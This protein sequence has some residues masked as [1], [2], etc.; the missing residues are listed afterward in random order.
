MTVREDAIVYQAFTGNGNTTFS[1]SLILP[2]PA[3][4]GGQLITNDFFRVEVDGAER[5]DWD[6]VNPRVGF[7]VEIEITPAPAV[8]A[9][10]EV[11][12][13]VPYAQDLQLD[14]QGVFL[15]KSIERQ[16]DLMVL[17][18]KQVRSLATGE[19][20]A[21]FT[22]LVN[23]TDFREAVAS[24]GARITAIAAA[25]DMLE[26]P[27]D[28]VSAAALATALAAYLPRADIAAQLATDTL[29][30]TSGGGT[31]D[32]TRN[33]DG[34]LVVG[35]AVLG[36]L[37]FADA[38]QNG[39]A[40]LTAAQTAALAFLAG[41]GIQAK[42]TALTADR[43]RGSLFTFD[44]AGLAIVDHGNVG[45]VL[46]SRGAAGEPAFTSPAAPADGSVTLEK[47]AAGAAGGL[48]FIGADGSPTLLPIGDPGQQIAVSDANLPTWTSAASVSGGARAILNAEVVRMA[49]AAPMSPASL[50]ANEAVGSGLSV[51]IETTA[52]NSAIQLN[53][54][55][56]VA[57]AVNVEVRD[58]GVITDDAIDGGTQLAPAWTS[59]ETLLI[60]PDIIVEG[61][62]QGSTHTF[63]VFLTATENTMWQLQAGASITAVELK[64]GA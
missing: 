12:S 4:V 28:G 7:P 15:P 64:V 35:G 36:S 18:I 51:S 32:L 26:Q 58:G 25:Q 62:A 22:G 24:L 30:L 16:L 40:A 34:D 56:K 11:F 43:D 42:L 1:T 61:G 48:F 2:A 45:E 55:V 59:D 46:T 50:G 47:M 38:A 44:A 57:G 6:F 60:L 14:N 8:G 29:Q 3:V 21:N 31:L 54:M 53:V 10:I 19:T 17:M 41:Q 52:A 49:G 33:A 37:A 23:S 39:G 9:A 13:V 27:A 5:T 20:S 63:N